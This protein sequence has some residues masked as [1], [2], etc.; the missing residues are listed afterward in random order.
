M[1]GSTL[2]LTLKSPVIDIQASVHNAPATQL[3]TV[4][5]LRGA[6]TRRGG[7]GGASESSRPL[8]V[9]NRR[10]PLHRN[11][12]A[13]SRRRRRRLHSYGVIIFWAEISLDL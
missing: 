12:K 10:R 11:M 3:L 13:P 9:A 5:D 8:S 4:L 6:A 2:Q 7:G 1:L